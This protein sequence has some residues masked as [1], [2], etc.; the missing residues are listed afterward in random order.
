LD[1]P[2]RNPTADQADPQTVQGLKNTLAA[3]FTS[4]WAL[5]RSS[6]EVDSWMFPTAYHIKVMVRDK[7]HRMAFQREFEQL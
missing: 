2:P 4:A 1:D 3:K 5:V 7:R 6:P